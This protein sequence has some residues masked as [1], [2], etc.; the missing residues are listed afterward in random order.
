MFKETWAIWPVEGKPGLKK[1]M[2]G[3]YRRPLFR[4]VV[5]EDRLGENPKCLPERGDVITSSTGEDSGL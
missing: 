2:F 3:K 1:E 5:Y 4:P